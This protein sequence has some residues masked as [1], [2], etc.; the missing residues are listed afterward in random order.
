MPSK[1]VKGVFMFVDIGIIVILLIGLIVGI[2]RGTA[3]SIIKLLSLV[4]G[5]VLTWFLA[6]YVMKFVF[7]IPL[8]NNLIIGEKISLKALFADAN[9][10]TLTES[11]FILKTVCTP[12]QENIG[13][14]LAA[15][16]ITAI[17]VEQIMPY[18]LAVYSATVFVSFLVYLVVRLLIMII[19][20]IIKAIFIKNVPG[21]FSRFIGAILGL[22]NSV[23]AIMWIFMLTSAIIG[24]PA[25]TEPISSQTNG[26]LG[27]SWTYEFFQAG[28]NEHILTDEQIVKYDYIEHAC[29]AAASHYEVEWPEPGTGTEPGSGTVTPE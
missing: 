6:P 11:S 14:I 19:A 9:I 17:T 4:G 26:S 28:F 8:L 25:L 13:A 10:A 12:L 15:K 3:K 24:M 27:V 2:V 20:A 16:E 21:G 23:V 5:L 1:T 22:V 29:K 7:D 18:A